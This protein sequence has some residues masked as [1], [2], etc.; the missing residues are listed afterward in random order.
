VLGLVGVSIGAVLMTVGVGVGGEVEGVAGWAGGVGV[1]GEEAVAG[2]V[3]VAEA[4]A[5][6]EPPPLLAEA[7]E[8]VA[9]SWAASCAAASPAQH[10]NGSSSSSSSSSRQQHEI[11]RCF[12]SCLVGRF[13]PGVKP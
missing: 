1:E 4:D 11:G 6:D 9:A 7:T 2:V 10:I 12:T 5:R 3:P 13:C 8:M